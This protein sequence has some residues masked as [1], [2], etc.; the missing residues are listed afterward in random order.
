MNPIIRIKVGNVSAPNSDPWWVASHS[1]GD[2][3]LGHF[4]R[5]VAIDRAKARALR[6]LSIRLEN[7]VCS[8]VNV[9]TFV[10]EEG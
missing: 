1:E 6:S 5:Q 8:S 10:V 4:D 2:T 9:I 3:P 7:S